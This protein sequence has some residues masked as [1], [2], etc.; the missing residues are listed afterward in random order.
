MTDQAANL[1]PTARPDWDYSSRWT[2]VRNPSISQ[3]TKSA[4]LLAP[5]QQTD[6]R[7][8]TPHPT[9]LPGWGT[10]S[11]L[12]LRPKPQEAPTSDAEK[13]SQVIVVSEDEDSDDEHADEGMLLD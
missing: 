5:A 4:S 6:D 13:D 9:A 7:V 2:S 12:E 8:V 10:F 11:T 3:K 1:H